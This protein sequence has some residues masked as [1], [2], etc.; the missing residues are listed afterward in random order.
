LREHPQTVV[1]Y[2][3]IPLILYVGWSSSNPRPPFARCA[4]SPLLRSAPTKLTCA[5]SAASSPPSP[6]LA[7][8]KCT[9]GLPP[10]SLFSVHYVPRPARHLLLQLRRSK[11]EERRGERHAVECC[12]SPLRRRFLFSRFLLFPTFGSILLRPLCDFFPSKSRFNLQRWSRSSTDN[13]VSSKEGE[14]DKNSAL[15]LFL[16]R[17]RR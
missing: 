10:L 13:G 16:E 8:Q 2:G 3:W 6:R 5:F 1:H 11:E 4:L 14:N 9:N 12:P 17:S 15:Y 7:F